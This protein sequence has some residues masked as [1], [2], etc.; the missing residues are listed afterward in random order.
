MHTKNLR[1]ALDRKG[2]PGKGLLGLVQG[3]FRERS[4]EPLRFAIV[5]ADR[6]K[7]FVEAIV[8]GRGR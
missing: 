5:K 2:I 1:F 4:L 3:Y 8:L 7:V 6:A